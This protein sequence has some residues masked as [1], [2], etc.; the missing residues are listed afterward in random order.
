M[1]VWILRFGALWPDL[2]ERYGPWKSVLSRF[3]ARSADA[4]YVGTLNGSLKLIDGRIVHVHKQATK[5]RP[6]FPLRHNHGG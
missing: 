4:T 3:R 1:I 5:K 6:Q 2:R